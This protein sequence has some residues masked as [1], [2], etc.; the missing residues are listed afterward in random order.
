M[1]PL[2]P[3]LPSMK[4]KLYAQ[5]FGLLLSVSVATVSASEKVSVEASR[6]LRVAVVDNS[7]VKDSRETVQA[8]LQSCLSDGMT[9]ACKA[10][11]SVVVKMTDASHAS[12]ELRAGTCDVVVV[13]SNSVPAVLLKHGAAVLKATDARSGDLNRTFYLLA[14]TGDP[15]MN[16]IVG[17]AFDHAMK[18][19]DFQD[20][21]AGRKSAASSLASA[22]R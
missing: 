7:G 20:A 13:I 18:S 2:A 19:A 3:I 11:A 8:A 4:T 12:K 16:Q 1:C 10:P 21:L 6:A 22:A 5:V 9:Y 14:N 15:A 17:L